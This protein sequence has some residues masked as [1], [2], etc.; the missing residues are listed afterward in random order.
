VS[1]L[2]KVDQPGA[3]S[4]ALEYSSSLCHSKDAARCQQGGSCVR[5]RCMRNAKQART[6][7]RW[8]RRD[9]RCD[10]G[11]SAFGPVV[12]PAPAGLAVKLS[13]Q[14]RMPGLRQTGTERAGQ[15]RCNA[16]LEILQ[17]RVRSSS[18]CESSPQP[19]PAAHRSLTRPARRRS[20]WGARAHPC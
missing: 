1:T 12:R 4:K 14:A 2:S 5:W 3:V 8:S 7:A 16:G 15:K 11:R 17:R 6:R 20:H 19:S 10:Q 9:L 18:W 13:W